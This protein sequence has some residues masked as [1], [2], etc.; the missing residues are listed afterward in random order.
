LKNE[1]PEISHAVQTTWELQELI[2]VGKESH[3]Q[4]GRY[5]SA[6]LLEMFS[7]PLVKGDSKTALAKPTSIVISEKTATTYFGDADPMGKLMRVDNRYDF[8]VT[9]VFL[10]AILFLSPI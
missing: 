8:E 10:I 9:G 7:F 1:V 4:T 6:D 2:T 3:K 5:A